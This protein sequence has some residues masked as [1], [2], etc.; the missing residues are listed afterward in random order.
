MEFTGY[1]VGISRDW[2][3]N[4][5]HIT[6]SLNEQGRLAS[7]DDIKDA[8][9]LAITAKKW[10]KKRSLNANNYAWQLMTELAHARNTSKEEIYEHMLRQCANYQ[11]D[12]D[13]NTIMIS[14]LEHIDCSKFGIHV[15]FADKE[16][17]GDK[18][19][20][21]YRVLKGS[22]EYDTKEM[23]AFIEFIV[24]ECKAEGID[25]I[26]PN[27]LAQIKASWKGAGYESQRR[28][29]I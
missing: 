27:E 12:E 13:G 23:S 4:Q 15:E 10:R 17:V 26:T 5:I 16:R 20:N 18:V 6:F 25:T 9:K 19:F 7:V 28:Q 11:L 21:H 29:N 2:K 14:A 24:S 8:E 3:T 1:L 22:S